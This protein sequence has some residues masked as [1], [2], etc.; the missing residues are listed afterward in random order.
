MI[1]TTVAV[2]AMA[3]L[4]VVFGVFVNARHSDCGGECGAC[5][6]ECENEIEGRAP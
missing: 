2:V 1:A 6:G 5:A 3:G 4:F